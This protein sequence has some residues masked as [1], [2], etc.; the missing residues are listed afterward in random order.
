MYNIMLLYMLYTCDIYIQY[1]SYHTLNYTLPKKI[2]YIS[3]KR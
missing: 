1:C 3:L 2:I